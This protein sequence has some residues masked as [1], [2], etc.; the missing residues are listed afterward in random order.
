MGINVA[1]ATAEHATGTDPPCRSAQ[2]AQL[3]APAEEKKKEEAKKNVVIVICE[4][5]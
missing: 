2:A 4:C 3:L 1:Q 5:E